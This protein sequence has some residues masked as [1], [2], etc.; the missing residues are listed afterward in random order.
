LLGYKDFIK[1]GGDEEV[2]QGGGG[3]G[4]S[5]VVSREVEGGAQ[6]M[7]ARGEG[8]SCLRDQIQSVN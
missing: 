5:E 3:I 1:V 4:Q 8:I 6:E 7:P 2:H